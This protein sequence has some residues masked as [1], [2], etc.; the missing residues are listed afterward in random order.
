MTTI[1]PS[2]TN[3]LSCRPLPSAS[4]SAITIIQV[5]VGSNSAVATFNH[6]PIH[7]TPSTSPATKTKMNELSSFL[8]AKEDCI[9]GSWQKY[10]LWLNSIDI[11]SMSLLV[12]AVSNPKTFQTIQDGDGNNR[13]R[14]CL[15]DEFKEAALNFQAPKPT[16]RSLTHSCFSNDPLA[17]LIKHSYSKK[18]SNCGGA[19]GYG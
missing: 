6:Q 12:R 8:K 17:S 4:Q 3:I 5:V 7:P 2:A 19:T 16:A 18:I 9:A 13:L 1:V 10:L 14:K 11:G 15:V